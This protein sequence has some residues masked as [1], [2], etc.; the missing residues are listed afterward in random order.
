M[1]N[2]Y[3]WYMLSDTKVMFKLMTTQKRNENRKQCT[4]TD[5]DG[6]N[7]KEKEKC[8]CRR[9]EFWQSLAFSMSVWACSQSSMVVDCFRFRDVHLSPRPTCVE[10]ISAGAAAAVAV[11]AVAPGQRAA[12]SGVSYAKQRQRVYRQNIEH[13]GKRRNHN[14]ITQF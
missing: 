12:S 13:A 10:V 8:C 1:I 14:S 11:V 6:N 2:I 5:D 3:G 4:I 9:H 7:N